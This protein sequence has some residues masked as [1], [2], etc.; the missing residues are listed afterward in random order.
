[1]HRI[2]KFILKQLHFDE[3]P[4]QVLDSS[5]MKNGKF[6]VK[7]NASEEGLVQASV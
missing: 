5:E 6:T 3:T 2:K 7:A 1:M 4:P